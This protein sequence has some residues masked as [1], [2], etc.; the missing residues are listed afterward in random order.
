MSI[1]FASATTA[2]KCR[3]E[4][5]HPSAN[6]VKACGAPSMRICS[7]KDAKRSHKAIECTVAL[8]TIRPQKMHCWNFAA[9][10]RPATCLR[11]IRPDLRRQKLITPT[12]VSHGKPLVR[13]RRSMQD[14]PRWKT[15]HGTCALCSAMRLRA[16]SWHARRNTLCTCLSFVPTGFQEGQSVI[17][18]LVNNGVLRT[19]L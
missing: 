14:G 1:D 18:N 17:D 9:L 3:S 6:A 19:C 13:R 16:A 12:T 8:R 5:W 11:L 4:G 7:L 15:L 2:W 10:R